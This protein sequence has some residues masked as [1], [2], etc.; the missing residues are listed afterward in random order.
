M[1]SRR[2][3]AERHPPTTRSTPRFSSARAMIRR[4]ISDVPSQIRSTRSSRKNRSA[5]ELAHVAAAAE[6]LD[7]AVGA[8]K[9]GLGCE[10]LG[11]RRLGVDD[12]GV[13][14]RCRRAR[15]PRGSAAAP[16]TRPRPSR[17]AGR[18]RPGSRRSARR[19]GPARWPIRRPGSAAAPS[20][21]C[22]ARRCGSAPRRTIRWSAR[23]PRPPRRGSPCRHADVLSTN[24][25]WR[26]ANVW[27]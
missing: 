22:S 8:P 20:P 10:Q 14:T 4:W 27:V 21:R 5:S 7:D 24:C 13:R 26:S 25:G 18:T 19:T 11:Q 17:P 12:L 23:P 3:D 1:P 2:D 6:D 16:P 15:P 9:G